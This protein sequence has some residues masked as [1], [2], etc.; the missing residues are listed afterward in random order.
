MFR[1]IQNLFAPTLLAFA[2][3][4]GLGCAQE[5]QLPPKA[6]EAPPVEALP[7]RSGALPLE[8][9]LNGVVRADNQMVVRPEVSGRVVEVLVKSGDAVELGQP[10]VR[11]EP[12]GLRE[13]LRQAEAEARQAR[14]A[15]TASKARVA[16]L[17][18][19]VTRT[20]K[21]AAEE[22]VSALEL[23]TLEARLDAAQAV[24]AQGDAQVEQATSFVDE[25]RF[26][27]QRA[28]VRAPSAGRVG[29]REVEVGTFATPSTALFVLGDLDDLLVE[30]E[31]TEAMLSF[32]TEGQPVHILPRGGAAEG[33]QGRRATLSRISPFLEAGSFI[34]TGEIDVDGNTAGLR[35]GM[36]VTVDILYGESEEATLVPSSALW[37]DPRTG[38]EGVYV[39]SETP[40]VAEIADGEGAEISPTEPVSPTDPSTESFAVE[41]RSVEVVAE[42]RSLVGVRGIEPGEWV[43]VVGQQLLSGTTTP[44]ARVRAA[45]WQRVMGLQGLQREDLL[46]G[47]IA[48]QQ[49]LAREQGA[50][51]PSNADYLRLAAP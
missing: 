49:R 45:S 17:E 30:I 23:E 25:R 35:P 2:L 33:T 21:L 13:Q 39:F 50:A 32:I 15:A 34:T 11:L 12:Q 42:G 1:R 36:F 29:R 6:S 46:A 10:L 5:T 18:A 8:E 9:R 22:L 44:R 43:V 16:E 14:A 19:E 24:A 51:P 47:F 48:K 40:T 20:R 41:L 7:A 27:L 37:E 28:V 3:T 4:L 38:I 31:L 26:D